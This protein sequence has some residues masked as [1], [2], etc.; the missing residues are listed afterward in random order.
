MTEQKPEDVPVFPKDE[1]VSTS[2]G[3]DVPDVSEEEAED[4]E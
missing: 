1:P 4:D 2:D 3:A